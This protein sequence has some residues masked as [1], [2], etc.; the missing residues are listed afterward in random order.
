MY[1]IL[2]IIYTSKT[3]PPETTCEDCGIVHNFTESALLPAVVGLLER[4]AQDLSNKPT[5]LSCRALPGKNCTN[6]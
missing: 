5:I 2:Y 4:S 1:R 3:K 6:N